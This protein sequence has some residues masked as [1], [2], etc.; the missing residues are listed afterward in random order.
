[1]KDNMDQARFIV[2]PD[3][4]R[5]VAALDEFKGQWLAFRN[6]PPE[7]I[8]D[9]EQQAIVKATAAGIRLAGETVTDSRVAAIL[10]VR[11]GGDRPLEE[12]RVVGYAK[13]L[14]TIKQTYSSIP[15]TVNHIKQLHRVMAVSGTGG[16]HGEYRHDDCIDESMQQLVEWVE[17]S[18]AEA[19]LH[20]LL[21]I[22]AFMVEF[23]NIRPFAT[24]NTRLSRFL[25]LLLLLK[26]GYDFT[27]YYALAA[28]I[29]EE[30][31][32]FQQGLEDGL[33][34]LQRDN[35]I[36][37]AWLFSFFQILRRQTRHI[38]DSLL[39][40]RRTIGRH[41]LE[42]KIIKYVRQHGQATNKLIQG[43]TGANRNTIKVHLRKLVEGGELVR[44][45]SGKSCCYTLGVTLIF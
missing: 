3:I 18:L 45:G 24:N 33:E 35:V 44:H 22:A 29:E 17:V 10:A 1:M 13:V 40:L 21:I 6:L 38:R 12:A 11:G 20:P 16:K 36:S 19:R 37:S 41:D 43:A 14:R 34:M 28:V 31:S 7:L 30:S 8:V 4:L 23:L 42:Q 39:D 5:L 15:F 25:V 26:C 32:M 9:L 27:R 2:T